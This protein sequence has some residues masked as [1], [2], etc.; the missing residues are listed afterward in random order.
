MPRTMVLAEPLS[1]LVDPTAEGG[2]DDLMSLARRHLKTFVELSLDL[3]LTAFLGC[4]RHVRSP[5]RK[6][7]RNGY[8]TRDL[9][10]GLGLLSELRVPR[11]RDRGFV[12]TLFEQYQRR[13]KQVDHLVRTLFF[14]GVST[15][16]VSEALEVLLGFEPSPAAVSSIVAEL[17]AQVKAFHRRPLSDDYVY[18]FLD[19]VTMT[20]KELPHAVKRLVL[21]AYGITREG[22]RVLLD[23]KIVPSES[24][25]E[26]E[27]FLN[28]LYERGLTG[29]Q[30]RLITTDGGQGVRAALELVYGEVSHQL[31]WAHKLRN[32]AGHLKKEQQRPCLRQAATI[33]RATNRR[34]ARQAWERWRKRWEGEAPQAVACLARDLEALLPF[35]ECPPAHQRRVRTTNYIERLFREVRRR[36]RLM[37]AFANKASCDRMLYGTLTRV[38]RNWSR[39]ALPGFTQQG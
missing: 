7:Y 25:T 17:D 10:T 18:L 30:L 8:Y 14:L 16:G 12:P 5:E 38:N 3:E 6:S 1:V 2:L 28:D 36:T 31:C 22:H 33:Y 27:R 11:C 19:G 39:K 9:A 26:W 23:Y 29:E 4:G 24:T 32:V 21:V 35:L 37:G 20:I 15:R 34:E 13:Q